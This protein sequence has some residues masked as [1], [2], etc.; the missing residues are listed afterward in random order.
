[1]HLDY[2]KIL[3]AF[4]SLQ[5]TRDISIAHG[6]DCEDVKLILTES[7][8][9]DIYR[10]T[11]RRVGAKK[12]ALKLTNPSYHENYS[13]KMKN[14]VRSALK[15]KM[16]SV[17][18]RSAWLNK[19]KKGSMKG[20]IAL[21]TYLDNEENLAIW[22]KRCSR[23]GTK[24]RD[25]KLG[26]FDP[27]LKKDRQLWSIKGLKKTGRK[28]K[29]PKDELMYNYL[30]KRVATI[31]F[32]H[33][34][35]YQYEKLIKKEGINPFFSVDFFLKNHNIIIEVTYWDKIEE[36]A[37][38]LNGKFLLLSTIYPNAKI[39]VVTKRSL[40]DSYKRLL[41]DNTFVLTPNELIA[42]I[43]LYGDSGVTNSK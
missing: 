21:K 16:K 40:R 23:A 35:K 19:A 5:S 9:E 13:V 14:S 2:E 11:Y 38:K 12:I 24:T 30:E 41:P 3:T 42:G 27:S 32:S 6:L 10:K 26:I 43:H 17:S 31:L 4:L 25:L 20:N 18:F 39:F 8:S 15:E 1:M 34:I 29:G 22:K 37:K 33:G 7:L 28:V 36:K